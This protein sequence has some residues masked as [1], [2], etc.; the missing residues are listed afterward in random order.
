VVAYLI[1]H[2]LRL[3]RVL[4][5]NYENSKEEINALNEQI[6]YQRE[7]RSS[8]EQKIVYYNNLR[9]ITNKIQN[10]S[11]KDLCQQLVDYSFLLLGKHKGCCLLYLVEPEQRN[12]KLCFSRKE[13]KDLVI[14][15]KQGDVFDHWVVRHSRSLL[16][17]PEE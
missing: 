7:F 2:H 9:D 16:V 8:L 11:L 3:S 10:L 5:V 4:Q 12:L 17:G 1:S 6:N 15:Q 14:K 13:D